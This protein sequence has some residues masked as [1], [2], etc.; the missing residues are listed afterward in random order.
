[1]TDYNML[2]N[3]DG[4]ELIIEYL[5]NVEGYST[6][7]IKVKSGEFAG[8][9]SFCLPKERIAAIIEQ[10]SGMNNDLKGCCEINDYDSDAYI[11]IEMAKFGRLWIFGQIGGSHEDHSVTFRYSTDQ[12]VLNSFIRLFKAL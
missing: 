6:F 8:K 1:M 4:K 3:S 7:T 5:Y 9:S 10:L 2:V 12:T 11:N